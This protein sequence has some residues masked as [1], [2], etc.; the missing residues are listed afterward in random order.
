[1]KKIISIVLLMVLL[2]SAVPL[3]ITPAAAYERKIPFAGE[4]NEL[5]KEELVNAILPYML[6]EG[7][8]KLDDVG[9][10]AYVYA[11]WNGKPRTVVDLADRT[12]EFYRPIERVVSTSLPYDRII[13]PLDRFDRLV[14]AESGCRDVP[15]PST[16]VGEMQFAYGGKISEVEKVR[17]N[18]ELIASLR[19]DVIFGSS[20]LQDQ[21]G[22]LTV[23]P[24][25]PRTE[26]R[27]TMMESWFMQI[28]C[29]GEVLEREEEAE[30]LISF[31]EEKMALVTDI[32]SQIDDSEKPRVYYAARAGSHGYEITK[33]TGYYDPIDLAGGI[34]VAKEDAVTTGEFVVS[35]ENIIK[36][37]PDIIFLKC[38]RSNPPSSRQYTI[39]MALLDPELQ[40]GNVNA[41][42]NGTVY[43]CMSTCRSYPIQRYIPEAMYFAKILHPEKFKDLDLEK[44][45]NEIMEKFFGEDDLYTWLADD[46]GYIRDLIEN[47]LEEGEW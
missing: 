39:E 22:T 47:P 12:L 5:T 25:P 21:T 1:M 37:N 7:D 31:M 19:P 46:R 44:E 24:S 35:K 18:V 34:N 3:A 20:R 41:V 32:S 10:A 33:T 40:A 8:L 43:Y 17:S 15:S 6:D 2:A 36:W 38:H 27:R 42:K 29:I 26:T 9:D 4:D 16:C 23:V 45:G 11:K 14:G 30:D 13:L 28:E